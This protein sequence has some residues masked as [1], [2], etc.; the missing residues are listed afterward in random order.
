MLIPVPKILGPKSELPTDGFSQ[1]SE[2]QPLHGYLEENF[3]FLNSE[4]SNSDETYS[5]KRFLNGPR[6]HTFQSFHHSK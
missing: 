1:Y 4:D 2:I 5:R 6:K 3:N